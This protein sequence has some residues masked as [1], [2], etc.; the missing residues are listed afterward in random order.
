MIANLRSVN[1]PKTM[2]SAVLPLEYAAVREN[3]LVLDPMEILLH[4]TQ[5]SLQPYAKA[6][7]PSPE[8][9]HGK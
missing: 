1:I 8:K 6:C 5:R 3:R 4:A 9:M 2:L 7:F